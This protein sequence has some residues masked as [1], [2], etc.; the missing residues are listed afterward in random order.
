LHGR[1]PG[2]RTAG[3]RIVT[4][5]GGTPSIGALLLRNVFR[6]I[7]SLPILYVVGLTCCLFTDRRVR[8]G[9]MAAG[10]LLVRE[11]TTAAKALNALGEIVSR[12]GLAP[13][14]AELVDDLLTRWHDLDVA[15]R[16]TLAR[17]ILA[18]ADKS[19]T[20]QNLDSLSD[21]VLRQRLQALLS[22]MHTAES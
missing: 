17:T 12:S 3:V 13:E 5:Q 1:T 2:K 10:T 6:L 11:Q 4:T 15:A 21:G 8:I 14:V 19:G 18:R 20:P 7:D 9:D 22:G 16:D